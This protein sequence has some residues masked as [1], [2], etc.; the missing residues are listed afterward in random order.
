MNLTLMPMRTFALLLCLLFTLLPARAAETSKAN[1]LSFVL[2]SEPRLPE[3]KAFRAQVEKRLAGRLAITDMEA[4]GRDVILLRVAGGTVM[5]GLIDAPLPKGQI[6]DLCAAA[7]YWRQACQATAG[8]RAHVAVSVL[9]TGLDKLDASLLLTDVV[10][11]LM[12]G[13]AI[14]SYWGA[15]LQSREAFLRQST[16]INRDQPPAWLWI[17]FRVSRDA[18]RGFSVSTQGMEQFDL[19]EIEAKDVSRPGLEVFVLLQGMAQYLISKGPVIQD[20]ETIGDS[21]ALGIRVHQGP[22]YWRDGVTVYRVTW[23]QASGAGAR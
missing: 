8:H 12:D 13:N 4:D 16:A 19:R 18:E 3:A 21:P 15:S 6:D 22:S 17:N 5:V 9:G 14:A 2:L 11:S 20:G 1:V 23:P 7:W 10:A